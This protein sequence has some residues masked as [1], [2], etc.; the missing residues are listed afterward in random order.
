MPQFSVGSD[1]A[2]I[3]LRDEHQR[4]LKALQEAGQSQSR[5]LRANDVSHSEVGRADVRSGE[6]S[7]SSGGGLHDVPRAGAQQ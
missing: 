3:F 5:Q 1:R 2:M 6:C 7:H 4:D